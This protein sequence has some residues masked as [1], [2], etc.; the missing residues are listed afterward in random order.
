MT[1]ERTINLI[2][3]AYGYAIIDDAEESA[4]LASREVIVSELGIGAIFE[5][6]SYDVTEFSEVRKTIHARRFYQLFKDIFSFAGFNMEAFHKIQAGCIFMMVLSGITRGIGDYEYSGFVKDA[7]S[8]I[9]KN[10]I[11]SSN[12]ATLNEKLFYIQ[13][14]FEKFSRISLGIYSLQIFTKYGMA[15]QRVNRVHE[16][17]TSR[18]LVEI[19]ESINEGKTASKKISKLLSMEII[20]PEKLEDMIDEYISYAVADITVQGMSPGSKKA[21]RANRK[22]VEEI[23]DEIHDAFSG[24][25]KDVA[26]LYNLNGSI[27]DKKVIY[28]REYN[29]PGIS[30]LFAALLERYSSLYERLWY[31]EGNSFIKRLNMIFIDRVKEMFA[32]QRKQE[33]TAV[34]NECVRIIEDGLPGIKVYELE[35]VLNNLDIGKEMFDIRHD[36]EPAESQKIIEEIDAYLSTNLK[37]AG[38]IQIEMKN[39]LSRILGPEGMPEGEMNILKEIV[40]DFD[41]VMD[42][43][44]ED[45]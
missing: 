23:S 34:K 2:N 21:E 45:E 25:K 19:I 4:L 11:S 28:D 24:L 32:E 37:T 20:S 36:I 1:A 9:G 27:L 15:I 8:K 38:S 16:G 22:L 33:F 17:A 44:T 41:A 31:Y 14:T 29:Q 40:Y 3:S 12:R 5:F 13:N 26:D 43:L 10:S 7:L 42:L 30:V 6:L 18:L 39:N 35:G